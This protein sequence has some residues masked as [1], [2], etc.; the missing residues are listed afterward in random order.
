MDD[1]HRSKAAEVA[2]NQSPRNTSPLYASTNLCK[3]MTREPLHLYILYSTCM[4]ID[5]DKEGWSKAKLA[6]FLK[7]TNE[8]ERHEARRAR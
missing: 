7:R 4:Q 1:M 3:K 2:A 8:Q 5:V 6:E